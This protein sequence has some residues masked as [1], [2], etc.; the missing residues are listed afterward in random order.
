[1]AI[2]MAVIDAI[3]IDF[4]DHLRDRCMMYAQ[5]ACYLSI[6]PIFHL[7]YLLGPKNQI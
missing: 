3:A 7:L 5:K 6:F 1:M 2:H 4:R